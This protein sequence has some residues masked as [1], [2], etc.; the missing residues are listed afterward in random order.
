MTKFRTTSDGRR[1]SQPQVITDPNTLKSDTTFTVTGSS[2]WGST[3]EYEVHLSGPD[4]HYK[5]KTQTEPEDNPMIGYPVTN[6][7]EVTGNN[8]ER[9]KR[10]RSYVE[11]GIKAN[12][13]RNWFQD[14]LHSINPNWFKTGGKMVTDYMQEG[15]VAADPM[16]EIQA[17]VEAAMSGDQQAQGA[18]EEILQK[19][20]QGD[21][22]AQ[23][24]AEVIKQM[25]QGAQQ[26][27][28]GGKAKKAKKA[29]RGLPI[30]PCKCKLARV[31]GKIMEVDSCTGLPYKK[32]GGLIQYAGLGNFLR[33]MVSSAGHISDA[34]SGALGA[35][36]V[37]DAYDRGDTEF[38]QDVAKKSLI[39]GAI[40]IAGGVAG[41]VTPTVSI[42]PAYEALPAAGQQAALTAG[43]SLLP[44]IQNRAIVSV[45]QRSL[46]AAV[47]ATEQA[48]PSLVRRILTSGV[49]A[50]PIV[51]SFLGASEKPE[52]KKT[53]PTPTKPLLNGE[54]WDLISSVLPREEQPEKEVPADKE[55]EEKNKY[56]GYF[57]ENGLPEYQSVSAR[58]KFISENKDWLSKQGFDIS[59]YNY[60]AAQNKQLATL[61]QQFKNRPAE[62]PV[63]AETPRVNAERPIDTVSQS[64]DPRVIREVPMYK[65]TTTLNI[66]TIAVPQPIMTRKQ[67]RESLAPYLNMNVRFKHG[68]KITQYIKD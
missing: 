31:G 17:L 6:T 53:I 65:P 5:Y 16:Q 55:T 61:I 37:R 2:P 60:S 9:L 20:Q 36:V 21:P 39:S 54:P 12:D 3:S 30:K 46:P 49:V 25:M 64:M 27:K 14:L 29:Q 35:D 13:Y 41:A 1:V 28:C 18:I 19:A 62:Q 8:P 47:R 33:K 56:K 58:K 63:S 10:Y 52:E 51:G 68:G 22:R 23:Q 57:A 15:G 38:A 4:S 11:E 45:A 7:V 44:A 59:K 26:M 24:Y 48:A 66:P 50:A 67:F 43:E 40:G 32:K 34:R 42:A